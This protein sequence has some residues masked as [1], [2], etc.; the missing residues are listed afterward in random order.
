MDRGLTEFEILP[1]KPGGTY[2][3]RSSARFALATQLVEDAIDEP[4]R[5]G[6]LGRGGRRLAVAERFENRLYLAVDRE[7]AGLR[8]RENQRVID[9]NVELSARARRDFGSFAKPPFE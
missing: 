3:F 6:R 2:R 4:C 9:E 7:A 8:L 1:G 5:F